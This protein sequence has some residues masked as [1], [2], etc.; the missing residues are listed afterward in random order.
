[1]ALAW[2]QGGVVYQVYPRSFQDTDGNGTGDLRGILRGSWG[3]AQ[4]IL[5]W[6]ALGLPLSAV[7]GAVVP[8]GWWSG[9]LSGTPVGLLLTMLFAAAIEVCSEGSAPIAADILNRA[10][11]PGNAFAFLMAG[12]ATDYT[13]ILVLRDAT[14]SWKIAFFLPLVTV[15]QVILLG[16]LMNQW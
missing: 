2:W 1:M 6:V 3:L 14:K 13:E 5:F 12:V 4:M 8:Q 10:F 16:Y 9:Y 7:L 11:A 15:P